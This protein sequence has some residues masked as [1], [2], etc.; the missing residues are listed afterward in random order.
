MSPDA[1]VEHFNVLKDDSPSIDSGFKSIVIQAFGFKC[2]K[3]T[4][5]R[6]II[7][8]ITFTTHRCLHLVALLQRPISFRTILANA[9]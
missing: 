1:I 2:A 3:E 6:R 8:T 9:I 4:F 7:P 5:Y